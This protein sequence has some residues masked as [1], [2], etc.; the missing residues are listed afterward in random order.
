ML[1]R[2]VEPLNQL[3]NNMTKE[4]VKEVMEEMEC[5]SCDNHLN[6]CDKHSR[7]KEVKKCELRFPG[8]KGCSCIGNN[9]P[10]PP[11]KQPTRVKRILEGRIGSLA[12][13]YKV[14]SVFTENDLEYL[15][16]KLATAVEALEHYAKPTHVSHPNGERCD[17]AR[18]ALKLIKE[19]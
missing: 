11:S 7:E 12:K 17:T 14:G 15:F 19:D 13:L 10:T 9:T 5:W 2:F 3:T 18:Q 6:I 1:A 8:H 4:E 16:S